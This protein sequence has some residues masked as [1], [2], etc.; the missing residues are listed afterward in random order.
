MCR[1][2]AWCAEARFV[3]SGAAIAAPS[4][5][6]AASSSLA[7][8]DLGPSSSFPPHFL[9]LAGLGLVQLGR[10]LAHARHLPEAALHFLAPAWPVLNQGLGDGIPN[11][12]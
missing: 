3:C 10:E 1:A 7:R 5:A 11:V 12:S 4:A 8:V 6:A 2:A 9:L